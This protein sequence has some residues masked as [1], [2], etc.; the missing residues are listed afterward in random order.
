VTTN[1]PGLDRI[2]NQHRCRRRFDIVERAVSMVADVFPWDEIE[3]FA[4]A[5]QANGFR[6]LTALPPDRKPS[7]DFE[8][9]RK[10][11][12]NRSYDEMGVLEEAA[13]AQEP[14]LPTIVD[15]RL[16]PRVGGFD[17]LIS[18]VFGVIKTHHKNY[19]HREGMQLRARG[20][21]VA[22]YR[23]GRKELGCPLL[24]R[25]RHD[26]PFLSSDQVVRRFRYD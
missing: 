18:P 14:N 17:P 8:K 25:Q 3:S 11:A 6:L 24:A 26:Q 13:L 23:E 7:Y 20:G 16:E 12:Q 21:L 4:A 10:A 5:L 2:V 9:M 15:G 22:S 19:L 1:V